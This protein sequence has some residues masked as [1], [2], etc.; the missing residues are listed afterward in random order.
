MADFK[1][2]VCSKATFTQLE[3]ETTRADVQAFLKDLQKELNE[4]SAVQTF[5][6]QIQRLDV[7]PPRGG[8]TPITAG[9][10]VV[11]TLHPFR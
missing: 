11:V 2:T 6:L 3:V 9:D 4:N 5:H 8:G 1:A 7:A 10:G